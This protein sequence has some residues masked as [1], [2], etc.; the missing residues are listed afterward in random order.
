MAILDT[1]KPAT[2]FH[3]A[4]SQ[5]AALPKAS[6]AVRFSHRFG[7]ASNFESLLSL[8]RSHQFIRL[9]VE[10]IERFDLRCEPFDTFLECVDFAESL[11]PAV[12]SV[13]R[14]IRR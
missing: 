12:A 10:L 14:H 11:L 2:G 5:Q 9:L 6:H 13:Q 8:L 1:H 4:S 7:L 3:H